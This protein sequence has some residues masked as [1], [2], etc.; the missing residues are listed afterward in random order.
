MKCQGT[1]NPHLG[2]EADDEGEP[3]RAPALRAARQ[4]AEQP[5]GEGDEEGKQETTREKFREGEGVRD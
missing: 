2:E 3:T 4:E 1:R 5:W